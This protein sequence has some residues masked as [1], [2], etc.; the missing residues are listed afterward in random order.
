VLRLAGS[1]VIVQVGLMTMGVVP[2]PRPGMI[3]TQ[4]EGGTTAPPSVLPPPKI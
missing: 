2:L 4:T 1:V 3:Q